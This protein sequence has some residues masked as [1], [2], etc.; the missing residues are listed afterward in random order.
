L[1]KHKSNAQDDLHFFRS[2]QKM[3]RPFVNPKADEAFLQGVQYLPYG[4]LQTLSFEVT[5]GSAADLKRW[6]HFNAPFFD[7]TLRPDTSLDVKVITV[8]MGEIALAIT[9]AK[10]GTLRRDAKLIGQSGLDNI[11]IL[12][13]HSGNHH[14][15]GDFGERRIEPGD[16]V[17]LDLAKACH[18]TIEDHTNTSII[19]NR[20][21]FEQKVMDL[22]LVHGTVLRAQDAMHKILSAFLVTLTDQSMH[23][24]KADLPRVNDATASLFA[25][26]LAQA[27][28]SAA[29]PANRSFGVSLD[30][31]RKFIEERL[32][33]PDLNADNLTDKFPLSRSALYKMFEPLGGVQGYIKK[34][35]MSGVFNALVSH[36]KAHIAIF[37]L[38]K[39]Y[40]FTSSSTFNRLFR[41][42]YGMTPR[43][44]RLS[45]EEISF[46]KAGVSDAEDTYM[47]FMASLAAQAAARAGT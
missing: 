20:R 35:R 16:F 19:L 3:P 10:G 11:L 28:A 47:Q 27:F 42:T 31:V 29:P 1:I 30:T 5:G 14:V 24:S 21:L 36:E 39:S 38:A 8:F 7:F 26:G 18:L 46:L 23:M 41:E 6:Q 34:R 15:V 43:D 12:Q 17:V 13:Y 9:C 25:A 44:L 32:H 22:N 4:E 40:G 33:D 45:A 37:D 2:P